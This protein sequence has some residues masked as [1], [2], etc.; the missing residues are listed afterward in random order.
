MFFSFKNKLVPS[1][2]AEILECDCVM[3]WLLTIWQQN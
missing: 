3:A 1:F 2:A